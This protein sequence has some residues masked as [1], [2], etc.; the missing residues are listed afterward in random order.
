[1]GPSNRT[2]NEGKNIVLRANYE[3][4][5]KDPVA[6]TGPLFYSTTAELFADDLGMTAVNPSSV[7]PTV[8]GTHLT[9]LGMRKQAAYWSAAIPKFEAKAA[10]A[11]AAAAAAISAA[12]SPPSLPAAR[13][14]ASAPVAAAK[15]VAVAVSVEHPPA[16]Q[17]GS[18]AADGIGGVD[19]SA[20]AGAATVGPPVDAAFLQ[21]EASRSEAHVAWSYANDLATE[22]DPMPV[23]TPTPTPVATQVLPLTS[24]VVHTPHSHVASS[25]RVDRSASLDDGRGSLGNGRGSLG[26][27]RGSLGNGRGLP[28]V[29]AAPFV[30][31]RPFAGEQRNY[32]YNRLPDSAGLGDLRPAVWQLSE[33]ST[34]EYVS[35]DCHHPPCGIARLLQ[36]LLA[37]LL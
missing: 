32:S 22:L 19:M 3:A 35:G 31:G 24:A 20:S 29:D 17:T 30:G 33:M 15:V 11:A 23:R 1:V 12:P 13:V 37:R 5:L 4:L 34:G 10:A 14:A 28:W 26:N 21:A 2:G 36:F 16:S 8:G 7:D 25:N 9:D 27:G 18:L 6:S